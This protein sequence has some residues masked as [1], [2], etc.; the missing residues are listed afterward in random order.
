MNSNEKQCSRI[1]AYLEEKGSITSLEALKDLGV[2]RLAS[3]IS[4]LKH[5]H[6]YDIKD[7]WIKVK[8]RYG[9]ECRIKRYL[10]PETKWE[11][12]KGQVKI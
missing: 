1:L 4:E 5:K 6:G 8:N 10:K 12:R 9:E 7:E 11:I 3:R 2:F